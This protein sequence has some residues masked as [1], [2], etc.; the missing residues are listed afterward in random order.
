MQIIDETCQMLDLAPDDA[1]FLCMIF[2]LAQ[3]HEVQ[4]HGDGCQRIAQFVAK[5]GKKLVLRLVR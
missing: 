3:I 1:T 5:H 4:S 2:V